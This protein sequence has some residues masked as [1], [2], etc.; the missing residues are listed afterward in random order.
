MYS[1]S[2]IF[3]KANMKTIAQP[4]TDA[5]FRATSDRTRLRIL[6]LLGGGELC[7]CHIVDALRV[8]Q[9][10]ASRH[11]AYLRRA[12]LVVARKDGLWIHYKL[13][14]LRDAFHKKLLECVAS[15]AGDDISRDAK[16]LDRSKC[17]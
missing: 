14:P 5:M 2:R 17:C 6:R 16:R 15:C 11:L 7:V 9:P 1:P 3:G 13:A 12:G 10:K 8:P 4:T